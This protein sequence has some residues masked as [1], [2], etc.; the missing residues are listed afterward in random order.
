M[1]DIFIAF[2]T[3]IS[4]LIY[5]LLNFRFVNRYFIRGLI[6]FIPIILLLI[7]RN[8]INKHKIKKYIA[9]ILI[10]LIVIIYVIFGSF[11]FMF[12][13]MIDG[14]ATIINANEYKRILNMEI[15]SNFEV[16]KYFPNE[17]PQNA[18]EI[19]F[20]YHPQFLQGGMEMKLE[21]K[22]NEE[23]INYYIDKYKNESSYISAPNKAVYSLFNNYGIHH[24]YGINL[25]KDRDDIEIY[26]LQTTGPSNHGYLSFIAVNNE[27]TEILFQAEK[28]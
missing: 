12:F 23:E 18:T 28:W 22:A 13:V 1:L 17:I 15:N 7:V 27:H 26:V 4:A 3:I 16:L 24:A 8:L 14:S 5:Y 6:F 11:L 9:S 10:I 2:L 25:N 19:Q 20:Y 21:F